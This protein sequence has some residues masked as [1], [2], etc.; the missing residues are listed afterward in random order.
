MKPL[1]IV[2]SPVFPAA[3]ATLLVFVVGAATTPRFFTGQNLENL[4]L[5]TSVVAIV[6]I[7]SGLT[8]LT[9]EIDLS[10]GAQVSLLSMVLATVLT[11]FHLSVPIACA[12][13]LLGGLLL[14]M[15]NGVLVAWGRVPSFVETL[16]TLSAFGGIALL[17][18]NGSPIFNLPPSLQEIFYGSFLGLAL[19]FWYTVVL[20]LLAYLFL[21]FTVSGRQIYAVGGN[22]AAA[23]LSG[24]K[25]N[26]IRFLAFALAGLA[27]GAGA[28]L[29]TARLGTGSPNLGNGLE[30]AAITA[31][32]VGGISLLGGRGG[33]FG[34][35]LGAVTIST[36]QNIL[37]L[38]SVPTTWQNIALGII[39]VLAVSLDAWKN[40]F[41][42]LARFRF[43]TRR[44]RVDS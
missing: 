42:L 30:L 38:N 5:Q 28:I 2:R 17:F 26:R 14:G 24:L 19:P 33:I 7:G 43:S 16:A 20:F 40:E 1:S 37:N 35:L 34:A 23:V 21:T 31:A 3:V 29:I 13:V 18:N 27:A 6:A 22:R 12:L 39:I 10:P 4:A 36:V 9:G 8:I 32:V 15:V 44:A 41:S 11:G 25:P